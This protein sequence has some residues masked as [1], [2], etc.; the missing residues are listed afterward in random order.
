[1]IEVEHRLVEPCHHGAEAEWSHAPRRLPPIAQRKMLLSLVRPLPE[2]SSSLTPR[3]REPDSNPRSPVGTAFFETPPQPATTNRPGSH[4][5]SHFDLHFAFR[6][7]TEETAAFRQPT[8]AVQRGITR[9]EHEH[10]LG[11]VVR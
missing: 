3:W 5:S 9:W 1:V 7:I 6:P 4:E 10:V 8:T 11:V 2:A